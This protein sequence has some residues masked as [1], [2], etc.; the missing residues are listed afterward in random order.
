MEV[1][2]RNKPISL[3]QYIMNTTIKFYGTGHWEEEFLKHP[4]IISNTFSMGDFNDKKLI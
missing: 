2:V 1:T 4:T 3:L